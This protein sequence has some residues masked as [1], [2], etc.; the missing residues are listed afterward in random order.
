MN[1]EIYYKYIFK[2]FNGESLMT[3]GCSIGWQFCLS[4]GYPG[5]DPWAVA[6]PGLSF[7]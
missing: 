6:N 4:P 5:I 1:V 2:D 3:R 7:K